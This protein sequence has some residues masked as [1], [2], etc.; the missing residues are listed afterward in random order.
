MWSGRSCTAVMPHSI[1]QVDELI[2][3]DHCITT[4]ELCSTLYISKGSVMASIALL[5][6]SK[7]CAH[8]VTKMPT[9]ARKET[10]TNSH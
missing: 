8:W 1:H 3:G 6:D 5:G 4:D 10:E 7:V 2:C 9:V